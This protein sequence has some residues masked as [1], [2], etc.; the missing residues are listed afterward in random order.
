M[1]HLVPR[2]IDWTAS[3]VDSRLHSWLVENNGWVTVSDV[4]ACTPVMLTRLQDTKAV[5][6]VAGTRPKTYLTRM[7]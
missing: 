4:Y 3:F 6:G 7:D 1:P 2:I 5:P